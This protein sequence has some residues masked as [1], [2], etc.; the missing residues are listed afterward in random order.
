MQKIFDLSR[1]LKENR[2]SSPG[3]SLL[4]MSVVLIVMGIIAGFTFPLLTQHLEHTRHK[5]TREHQRE[6]MKALEAYC[7]DRE[8]L[9]APGNPQ[10][11]EIFSSL[12]LEEVKT[13]IV[14]YRELGLPEEMAK[15]GFGHY[16]TYAPAPFL[17]NKGSARN[18]KLN[19]DG[20]KIKILDEKGKEVLAS[21]N[22]N[23]CIAY[24]LISYGPEGKGA[25]TGKNEGERFKESS[26]TNDEKINCRDDVLEFK[27]RPYSTNPQNP[28]RHRIVWETHI[29]LVKACKEFGRPAPETASSS[30]TAQS[31]PT[32]S[33]ENKKQNVMQGGGSPQAS[34]EEDASLDPS[35][36]EGINDHHVTEGL[37]PGANN[38]A[39]RPA[40]NLP[41][42]GFKI[43]KSKPNL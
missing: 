21:S 14:P 24:I 35:P 38:K 30:K 1:K 34:S 15:D 32:S 40:P 29:K 6:V 10:T 22:S 11:G 26:L 33:K 19:S 20:P 39:P 12:G 7:I 18:I 25:Y 3:F 28:F 43:P 23:D 36:P 42:A 9:P 37:R 31:N 41:A 8:A 5:I 17:R 16:M 13:G 4:E 27:T 2:F